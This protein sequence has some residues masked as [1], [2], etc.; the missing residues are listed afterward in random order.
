MDKGYIHRR[1]PA[2]L[3]KRKRH[4]SGAG[5]GAREMGSVA[6]REH[7]SIVQICI[8]LHLVIE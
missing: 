6:L 3:R 2:F 1:A 5:V 8:V 7:D 4:E